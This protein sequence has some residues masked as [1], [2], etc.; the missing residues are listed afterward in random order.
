MQAVNERFSWA[1]TDGLPS[2][3]LV[4]AAI[5]VASL[6]DRP[7]STVADA[8][9]SYWRRAV[10]GS[11]APPD[12]R[13]GERLLLD[14]G[15]VDEREGTLYPTFELTALLD[16]TID[17]AAAA[18]A[19]RALD[20]Q[21][22]GAQLASAEIEEALGELVPDAARREELLASLGRKFDDAQRQLLGAIGEE[23]VVRQARAELEALGYPQLARA[24]RHLSLETDQAGYDISAPRIVGNTRLLEVKATS[25]VN[26]VATVHLSRNEAETGAHYPDWALVLCEVDD[27]EGRTGCVIGW[28]SA[29]QLTS[30]FPEDAG[31]G[32]WEAVRIDLPTAWL[33]PGLPGP[34]E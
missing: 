17:D 6:L 16:G 26:D 18:I 14:V 32:R 10:G 31:V 2:A 15:L 29:A 7:G 8:R 1:T 21:S 34:T 33:A 12:L 13:Q 24:V 5:H 22:V 20:L 23:I 3:Y 4:R 27:V 9:E 30:A 25:R 19:A 11:F 28:C